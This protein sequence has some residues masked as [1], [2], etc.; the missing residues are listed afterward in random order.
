MSAWIYSISCLS[1]GKIYI[2]STANKR[3]PN[4]RWV[5][6]QWELNANRH[7]NKHLQGSWLK[8]GSENFIFSILEE[9]TLELILIREQHFIDIT[10]AAFNMCRVSGTTKGI[11]HPPRPAGFGDKLSALLKGRKGNRAGQSPTKETRDKISRTKTGVKIGPHSPEWNRKIGDA[12]RGD[13]NHMFGKRFRG[14]PKPKGF[15]SPYSKSIKDQHGVVYGSQQQAAIL[16]NLHQSAI[17][18]VLK[19]RAIQTGGYRFTYA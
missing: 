10:K 2:G 17:N 19:N 1:N 13:R 4:T 16:L 5:R 14:K 11:K 9:T 12:Q 18:K 7:D 8:Y 6:H 3:G 15:D